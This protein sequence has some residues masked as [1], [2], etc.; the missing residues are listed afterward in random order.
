MVIDANMYWFDEQVFSDAATLDRFLAEVPTAYGTKGYAAKTPTG[1]TQIVIERPEGFAGLNYVEGDYIVANQLADMDL[2]GVDKAILKIPGCHEWLSLGL[3]KR[4]N[5]GMA[6]SAK[7]SGGRLVPLAVVPPFAGQGALD[8]LDRCF[9]E[10]GFTGVQMSAHYGNKYL[11]DAAFDPLFSYLNE[12][13]ATVYVHH[14]P[15][16][17]DCASMLEHDNLRRS[18]GRCVDQ[19]T[20]VGRELYGDFFVRYPNLKMVHSMLGGGYFGIAN[21]LMPHGG[22]GKQD[23]ERFQANG[24]EYAE[25]LANN[26]FFEMSH[27]QPWGKLQLECA[28]HVLGADHVIFGTSYPVRKEWLTEGVAAVQALDIPQEDK[29]LVLHGNA[30]RLYHVA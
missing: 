18:Y 4:F 26:V 23:I 9:D 20:A 17:V 7:E 22:K 1:K 13:S 16:P 21:M 12:R 5:D 29:E 6:A 10:L 24:E 8:E 28:V 3:C 14:V 30:E 27:A 15:V 19:T 2:G 25:H 11:D